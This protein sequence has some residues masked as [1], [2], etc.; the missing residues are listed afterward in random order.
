MN[1]SQQLIGEKVDVMLAELNE[2]NSPTFRIIHRFHEPE[3]ICLPGEEVFAVCLMSRGREF[4]LG[5]SLSLRLVFDYLARQSRVAQSASQVAAGM[6]V[7]DFYRNHAS[8]AH[9]GSTLTR[10]ISRS[11]IKLYIMRIRKSLD[12]A[13]QNANLNLSSSNVLV[14]EDTVANEVR[15]RLRAHCDWIHVD[16]RS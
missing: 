1:N 14:S 2:L 13:F 7:N 16:S 11:A 4:H 9:V 8:N 15:Y 6:R 3:T 5:L 12:L 10:K